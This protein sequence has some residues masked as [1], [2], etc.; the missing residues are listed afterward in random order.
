MAVS[1]FASGII[2]GQYVERGIMIDH[3]AQVFFFAVDL[4]EAGDAGQ[5]LA[6][7]KSYVV[8]GLRLIVL[9]DG[10]VFK[11]DFHLFF[12]LKMFANVYSC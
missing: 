7:V 1:P 2:K 6:D 10:A 4:R 3:G 9:H 8:S 12:L 11:C 5:A